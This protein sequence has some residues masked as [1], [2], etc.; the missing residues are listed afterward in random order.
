ML[1]PMQVATVQEGDVDQAQEIARQAAQILASGGLVVFPTETVY[2]VGA[3]V[4]SARGLAALR[5][6][7]GRP[8]AQPFTVHMPDP[9]SAERYIDTASPMLRR[10]ISKVFP[11]PVTLVVDVSDEI[12]DQRLKSLGLPPDARERL[13]HN[14]TIGLRCP[15]H[16]LAQ[17]IL[18]AINDPIVASSA[19][20][21]GQAPPYD[22][23]DAFEAIGDKVDL[24][25]DGGRC[26][27]AKPS[28]IVRVE[29]QGASRRMSV[30]R[31][32]VYDERFIR[33]LLRWT[34]LFVCSGNTCR[35]P[36]AEAIAA[37]MLA[38]ERGI[39]VEDLEAAGIRV[40]SAGVFAASGAPA[41]KEAIDAMSKIGVDLSRHRSRPITAEMIHEADVIYCMTQDHVRAVLDIVP[42]AAAKVM[43]LDP[44]RDIDDPMGSGP[45]AY[46]RT[47]EMIRRRLEQRLKEQQ[48]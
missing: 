16:P 47:A 2:G 39:A 6:L 25:V 48:P 9:A 40:M 44:N 29:G 20:L 42:S 37:K 7:K 15:D 43:P 21:R 13:Y 45:T 8:D 28:T 11:G 22:A 12:I 36:M 19:N 5:E 41:T 35:S 3:S 14:N 32:G 4:A 23:Q 38:D 17:R 34:A 27:Y 24:V 30:L 33:K 1:R 26:R 46:Q 10:L 18:G 31:P